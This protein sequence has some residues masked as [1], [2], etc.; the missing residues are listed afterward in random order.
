MGGYLPWLVDGGG[1]ATLAG[2]W[3]GYLPWKVP[4]QSGQDRGYPKVS[5]P[6]PVQGKYPPPPR[7]LAT[8]RYASC[9]QAGGYSCFI[10]IL[11]VKDIWMANLVRFNSD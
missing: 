10:I 8:L 5:N 1:R 11:P 3:E 6:P 9:V 2:G 7:G 4:P